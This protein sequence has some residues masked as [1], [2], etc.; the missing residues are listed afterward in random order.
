MK[1][2]FYRDKEREREA[3]HERRIKPVKTSWLNTADERCE[4]INELNRTKGSACAT[5]VFGKANK[6]HTECTL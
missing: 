3:F 6:K 1:F 4:N 2:R 5:A